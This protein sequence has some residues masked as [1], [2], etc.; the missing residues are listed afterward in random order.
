MVEQ[1]DTYL[2]RKSGDM[3]GNWLARIGLVSEKNGCYWVPN[4][5]IA[6]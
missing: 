1:D 2:T 3:C 4:V 6:H 5:T